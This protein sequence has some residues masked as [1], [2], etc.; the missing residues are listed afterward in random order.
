MINKI[1]K[2]NRKPGK[3]LAHKIANILCDDKDQLQGLFF[4][5]RGHHRMINL[6]ADRCPEAYKDFRAARDGGKNLIT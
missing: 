1:I 6:I 4:Y 3:D 5:L 2:N